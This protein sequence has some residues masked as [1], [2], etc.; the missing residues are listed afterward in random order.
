MLA[1][2]TGAGSGIGAATACALAARGCSLLLVG[3]SGAIQQTRQAIADETA[4]VD[5]YC[6]QA[7]VSLSVDRDAIRRKVEAIALEI[8]ER[9]AYVIQ[10]AG[11][12]A[13]AAGLESM[14][15]SDLED[16]LTIN[17]VGPLAL[18][19]DLLPA[20]AGYPGGARILFIGAGVDEHPQ[21]GTGSY[22]ISKMALKRLWHQLKTDLAH[23]ERKGDPAVGLFQPGVVDT[24]GL[25]AHI[26]A[27]HDNGLPHADYL[28]QRLADGSAHSPPR[29]VGDAIARLLLQTGAREFQAQ[30]WRP[31]DCPSG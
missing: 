26:Q 25:R 10:A 27:A 8:G 23:A 6:Q 4:A 12:G 20:L 14:E 13:P 22:G 19:R 24:P 21:P 2:V 17:V 7:D 15:T 1:L 30:Q 3:R 29:T 28:A 16:A 5:V 18:S 31:D 11:V 9:L